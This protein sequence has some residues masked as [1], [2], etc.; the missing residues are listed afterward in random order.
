MGGHRRCRGRPRASPHAGHGVPLGR[1]CRSAS[2]RVTL[3]LSKNPTPVNIRI[4]NPL[5][6]PFRLSHSVGVLVALQMLIF[7]FAGLQI[8]RSGRSKTSFLY[9][10]PPA[11]PLRT[12][13]R[14]CKDRHFLVITK[15]LEKKWRITRT[16]SHGGHRESREY[17]ISGIVKGVILVCWPVC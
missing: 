1:I 17:R 6:C 5:Y 10:R 12:N 15:L 3:G 7:S 2:R 8:L 4:F 16:S 13:K 11:L 14:C 9:I